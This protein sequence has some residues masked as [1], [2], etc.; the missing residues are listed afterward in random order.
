MREIVRHAV[1]GYKL[2]VVHVK[3]DESQS[4][5]DAVRAIDG[6]RTCCGAKAAITV[7]IEDLE[8]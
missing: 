4:W 6:A 3:P 1:D 8:L 7:S 2:P 5:A